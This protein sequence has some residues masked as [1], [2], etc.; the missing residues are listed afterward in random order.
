MAHQVN[1]L[2]ARAVRAIAKP[3]R[4]ADGR[5][6]YLNLTA[7]GAR[8]WVFLYKF[9][10]R[11]R[12]MGLGSLDA[13]PLARARELATDAR[14]VLAE[15]R[16]PLTIKPAP[17]ALT[18]GEIADQYIEAKR[19]EWHNAKHAAQ[20]EMTL[21]EYAAPIR[22][23]A[24]DAIGTEDVLRC[25]KPIWTTTPETVGRVRGRI[26]RVLDAAAAKKLRAGENP[27]RWRGHL[28]VWSRTLMV[29]SYC[30]NQRMR[31]GPG[32]SRERHDD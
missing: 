30:T 19:G 22:S 7:T 4:H 5:N 27:A 16:D 2:S 25:L 13:V 9:G 23:F 1:R 14:Q 15:G 32:S 12:E 6:L 29:H 20:W 31:Y 28:D 17:K 18:F 26:E 21:R 3:G 11:Q 8:S 24:V 10:G